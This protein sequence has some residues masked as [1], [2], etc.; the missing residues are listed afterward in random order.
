MKTKVEAAKIARGAG[1]DMIITSGKIMHPLRAISEGAP[2]TWFLA[3]SDPVTAKRRWIS[4]QLEPK[5]V[6]VVD[7][8]A[9]KA[10][11]SGKSL[12]PAGVTGVSGTFDR[13][14]VVIIRSGSGHELGRGLIA[15]AKADAQRIIGKRSSEIAEILG[16]DGRS[17]LIHRDD[18]ALNRAPRP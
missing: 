10:L 14:D 13:G 4:G 3:P 9:E 12:L 16:F 8:G 7:T 5:G 18:M 2:S 17:E 11:T 15:Y 1:C 6:V